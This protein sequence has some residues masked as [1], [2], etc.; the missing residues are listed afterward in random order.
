[1]FK[2]L[3]RK[4]ARKNADKVSLSGRLETLILAM[5]AIDPVRTLVVRP[6]N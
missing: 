6:N 5:T 4:L 3:E 1:M 2:L